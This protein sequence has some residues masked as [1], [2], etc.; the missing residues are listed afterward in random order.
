MQEEEEEEEEAAV[1]NTI[2]ICLIINR[3][4]TRTH[5]NC[6]ERVTTRDILVNRKRSQK[7]CT[8]GN[9]RYV[10]ELVLFALGHV[11]DVTVM[12]AVCARS[13]SRSRA[14]SIRGTIAGVC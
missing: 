5:G 9:G 10:W 1:V 11:R 14:A 4:H 3:E 6:G 8:Y 2:L 7:T 12:C 13:R